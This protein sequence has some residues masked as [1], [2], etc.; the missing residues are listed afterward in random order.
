MQERWNVLP[1]GFLRWCG[2]LTRAQKKESGNL[3]SNLILPLTNY[4]ILDRSLPSFLCQKRQ[5]PTSHQKVPSNDHC[6][7]ELS[8]GWPCTVLIWSTE[9]QLPYL[10]TTPKEAMSYPG[11]DSQQAS[12]PEWE[13]SILTPHSVFPVSLLLHEA[14]SFKEKGRLRALHHLI[15]RNRGLPPNEVLRACLAEVG[16]GAW[17]RPLRKASNALV[18]IRPAVLKVPRTCLPVLNSNSVFI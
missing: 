2:T 18:Y 5:S 16:H 12:E 3:G 17:Y 15:W 8:S 9:L 1:L 4:V 7:S 13:H 14:R 11:L 6:P 10:Q